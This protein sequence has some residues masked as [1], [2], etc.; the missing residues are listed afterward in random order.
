MFAIIQGN[1]TRQF[2][3]L[4]LLHSL[5]E[6]EFDLLR[7]RDSEAVATLEF[8]IHELLRQIAVERMDVKNTMQG[9][10]LLEYATMLPDEEGAEVRRLFHLI[11]SLEQHCARQATRNTELSLA[12]LDQSQSLLSFLHKQITPKPAQCYGRS[13]RISQA[14]PGAAIYSARY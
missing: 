3:A 1:L 9:T 4:E 2:K 11:D 8:S 5:L 7:E 12:L 10:K 6:E 13:G 14:R